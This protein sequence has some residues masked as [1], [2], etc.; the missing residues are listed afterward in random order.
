MSNWCNVD[1]CW[2]DDCFGHSDWLDDNWFDDDFL[3]GLHW[4]N[5]SCLDSF[6][7]DWCNECFL[8]DNWD[9]LFSDDLS[10]WFLNESGLSEWLLDEGGLSNRFHCG[11]S[12]DDLL[13]R[14]DYHG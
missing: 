7:Y 3:I 4:L 14:L 11:G 2:W 8:L 13:G 5:N 1:G 9:G 10:Y 12:S 6:F